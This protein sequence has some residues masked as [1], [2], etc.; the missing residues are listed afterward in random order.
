MVEKEFNKPDPRL[1]KLY[2]HLSDEEMI[3]AEENLDA[4]IELTW[5]MYQRIRRDPEEYARFKKLVEE[6]KKGQEDQPKP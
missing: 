2:P 3:I 4:Y 5:N 1:R 6:R